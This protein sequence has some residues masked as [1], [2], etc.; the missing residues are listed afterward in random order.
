[1]VELRAR[2]RAAS[3]SR[4][5]PMAKKKAKPAKKA[6]RAKKAPSKGKKK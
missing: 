3:I 1:M 4:G 5:E 2:K 6:K